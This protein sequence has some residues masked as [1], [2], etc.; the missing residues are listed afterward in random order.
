MQTALRAVASVTSC[1]AGEIAAS[2]SKSGALAIMKLLKLIAHCR[3]REGAFRNAQ[4]VA[5]MLVEGLWGSGGVGECEC[6]EVV[7][8]DGF[9]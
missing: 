6:E 8:V 1:I 9:K 5:D 2:Q 7:D 3:D 4:W